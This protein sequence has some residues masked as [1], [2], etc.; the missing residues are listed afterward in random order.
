MVVGLLLATPVSLKS[1]SNPVCSSNDIVS[2]TSIRTFFS[3][4][5]CES[6]GTDPT[7]HVLCCLG[8][9]YTKGVFSFIDV[10][11]DVLVDSHAFDVLDHNAYLMELVQSIVLNK[12]IFNVFEI[13]A[14]T[15]TIM[16]GA[17]SNFRLSLLSI[18]P[19]QCG[20]I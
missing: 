2:Y 15:K 7:F 13:D 17:V 16:E 11:D 20:M 9:D 14:P 5:V 6:A 19:S 8:H 18:H 4:G 1:H 10:A 12:N 3:S